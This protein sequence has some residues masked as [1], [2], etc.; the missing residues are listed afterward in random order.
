[1]KCFFRLAFLRHSREGRSHDRGRSGCWSEK[2][3]RPDGCRYVAGI[4]F[5]S[6]QPLFPRSFARPYFWHGRH[7]PAIGCLISCRQARIGSNGIRPLFELPV[8]KANPLTSCVCRASG[9][10]S[11][12]W[13][14]SSV[15]ASFFVYHF[16]FCG[17]RPFWLTSP[18]RKK[19]ASEATSMEI[20]KTFHRRRFHLSQESNISL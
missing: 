20:V 5:G 18:T 8:F 16:Q 17:S 9:F 3:H 7:T 15:D 19:A 10:P 4:S 13:S 11:S 12:R 14:R 6:R 2:A 1:M